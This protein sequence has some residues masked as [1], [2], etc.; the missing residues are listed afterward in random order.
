VVPAHDTPSPKGNRFIFSTAVAL[1]SLSLGCSKKADDDKSV[2]KTRPATSAAGQQ[3]PAAA[4]PTELVA[5][6]TKE[7][8]WPA[9]LSASVRS[10]SWLFRCYSFALFWLVGLIRNLA[11][12][13][14]G[15]GCRQWRSCLLREE[16][17]AGPS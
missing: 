4:L 14:C 17:S 11:I 9:S 3:E 16:H 2:A 15:A 13:D 8:A 5:A 10:I 6:W 12:R 1:F 7:G